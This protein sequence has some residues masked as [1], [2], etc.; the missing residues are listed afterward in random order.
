MS[1]PEGTSYQVT[2]LQKGRREKRKE[3]FSFPARRGEADDIIII[4]SRRK[5]RHRGLFVMISSMI[6]FPT[7]EGAKRDPEHHHRLQ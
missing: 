4:T 3:K 7:G 5:T 6:L 1:R 2:A